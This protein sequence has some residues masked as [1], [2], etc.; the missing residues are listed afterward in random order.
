[1]GCQLRGRRRRWGA[2]REV[3]KPAHFAHKENQVVGAHKGAGMSEEV[4]IWFE[5]RSDGFC[6][7]A[8][9]WH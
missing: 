5:N 1:M 7:S 9:G 8:I 3:P 6:T 4:G 2:E